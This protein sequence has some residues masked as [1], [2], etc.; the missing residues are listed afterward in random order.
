MRRILGSFFVAYF[1]HNLS[2]SKNYERILTFSHLVLFRS[3]ICIGSPAIDLK[4]FSDYFIIVNV[5]CKL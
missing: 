3:V 5:E 2:A 4:L 1:I